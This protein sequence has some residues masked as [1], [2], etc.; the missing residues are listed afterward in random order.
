MPVQYR[1]YKQC[2]PYFG[3]LGGVEFVRPELVF[4]GDFKAGMEMASVGSSKVGAA[5]AG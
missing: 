3:A 5:K 2:V 4:Y 1:G